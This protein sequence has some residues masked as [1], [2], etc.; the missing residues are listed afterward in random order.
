METNTNDPVTTPPD[1]IWQTLIAQYT[2]YSNL[3]DDDTVIN[4]TAILLKKRYGIV[5]DRDVLL[6][7]LLQIKIGPSK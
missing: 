1:I 3:L 6:N 7:R 4:N 2:D 5:A